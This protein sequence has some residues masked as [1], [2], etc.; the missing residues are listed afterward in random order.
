MSPRLVW[1]RPK[2]VARYNWVTGRWLNG[3]HGH[4]ELRACPQCGGPILSRDSVTLCYECRRR[5]EGE[6]RAIQ[7]EALRGL[8]LL[9]TKER[10]PAPTYK[11]AQRRAIALVS[12]AKAV[13]K[14][15]YLDGSIICVDCKR[16][17][18]KVYDHRDYSKPLEVEPVCHWCNSRRGPALW[19]VPATVAQ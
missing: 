19:S 16:A 7:R 9:G 15:P 4:R 3:R 2:L 18:A 12:V 5:A 13:R 10:K 17:P 1:K 14:L 6:R 11:I 8:G